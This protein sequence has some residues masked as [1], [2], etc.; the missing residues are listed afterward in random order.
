MKKRGILLLAV[1]IGLM[2]TA[3]T[4][5]PKTTDIPSGSAAGDTVQN[6]TRDT[7]KLPASQEYISS[8]GSYKVILFEGLTQTDM[9]LQAGSSMM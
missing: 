7:E 9:P 1:S 8:D 6:E 4:D 3:C 5:S 2:L